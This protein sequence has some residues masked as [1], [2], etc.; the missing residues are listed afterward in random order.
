MP[1]TSAALRARRLL[2]ILHLFE[3]ESE[4]SIAELALAVGAS[5]AE[6]A[7]DL[8]L[9][10][11]CA[12]DQLDPGTFM[13]V[14][15]EDGVVEIWNELPALD[16]PVRLSSA[17]ARA[18]VSALE[19]AGL[20]TSDAL[21]SRLLD[22][23]ANSDLSV[24]ALERVVRAATSPTGDALKV[25]ALALEQRRPVRIGYRAAGREDEN[26]REIEPLGLVNERG[27]WY[28]E[29]FCRTAGALR[30]FRV[31]RVSHA[32]VLQ[33]TC[34]EREVTPSGTAFVA[35]G[36]PLARV[37]L[38]PGETASE[39][40]WPGMRVVGRAEDGSTVVEVPYAGTAWIARQVAA[41]LG[42]AEALGPAEVR[43]AVRA[44]ALR[45]ARR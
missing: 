43:A 1:R 15:V 16:R 35:T 27:A 29:A 39:R 44:L 20:T 2:A 26:E 12:S 28:L 7:E 45:E 10:S 14:I 38:L 6:I 18:L 32:E 36:L 21:M 25:L 34:Q 5:E 11:C 33:G 17:E 4:Y 13:P 40:E 24:E 23:A 42:G 31:D 8:N 30:T 41:R 37:R 9:L 19:T 22:A 3:P